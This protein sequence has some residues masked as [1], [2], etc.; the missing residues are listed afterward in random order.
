MNTPINLPD[1]LTKLSDHSPLR[2][3][4]RFALA[5]EEANRLADAKWRSLTASFLRR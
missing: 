3:L 4:A 2:E 5:G 1:Y